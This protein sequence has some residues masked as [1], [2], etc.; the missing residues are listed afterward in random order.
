MSTVGYIKSSHT[1]NLLERREY[2]LFNKVNIIIKD[3]LPKT[4]NMT[5]VVREV[6]KKLPRNLVY[7]LDTIYVGQFPELNMRE[8]E[9]VYLDGAIFISNNQEDEG[10]MASSIIHEVAHSLEEQFSEGIYGDSEIIDEFI[11]KRKKLMELLEAQG[12]SYSNKRIYLST[13]F[14][15][16]FDNFLYRE[17][18]YERLGKLT[19]G[20]FISPYCSTSLREYFSGGFEKYFTGENHYLAKISPKLHAKITDLTKEI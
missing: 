20:L 1:R 17:V 4:I 12:F 8:V 15:E 3:P 5:I 13:D 2:S 7:N 16:G 10:E 11:A 9:S 14:D 6:E 19:T 18:G